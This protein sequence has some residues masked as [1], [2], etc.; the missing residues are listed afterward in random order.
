MLEALL[1]KCP[2]FLSVGDFPLEQ[3]AKQGKDKIRLIGN[4]EQHSP[5]GTQASNMVQIFNFSLPR[6]GCVGPHAHMH[7]HT[8]DLKEFN[9]TD[10]VLD[11]YVFLVSRHSSC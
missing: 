9:S 2:C 5:S 8:R 7:T 11:Y 6:I 1:S 3:T 4:T 10:C